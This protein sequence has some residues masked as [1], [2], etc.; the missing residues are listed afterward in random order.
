M[1]IFG[2]RKG[3]SG[4]TAQRNE[5]IVV[6]VDILDD[7]LRPAH[8]DGGKLRKCRIQRLVRRRA[9]R[10]DLCSVGVVAPDRDIESMSDGATL[11]AEALNRG[12]QIIRDI[13]DGGD[14]LRLPLIV[15]STHRVDREDDHKRH[16]HQT[17]DRL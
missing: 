3:S 5:L 13:D 7:W 10:P 15:M 8:R 17:D 11:E 16:R 9:L 1:R 2:P 12:E 6:L 14:A 4:F